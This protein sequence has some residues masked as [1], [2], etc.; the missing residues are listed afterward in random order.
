MRY[1]ITTKI[2]AIYHG[3]RQHDYRLSRPS[4]SRNVANAGHLKIRGSAP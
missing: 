4:S 1:N 3:E 2:S